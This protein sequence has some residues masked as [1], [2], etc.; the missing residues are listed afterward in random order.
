MENSFQQT[1]NI[2]GLSSGSCVKTVTNILCGIPGISSVN[3]DSAMKKAEVNS[4]HLI[5]TQILKDALINT[6]Y[7]ISEL[8]MF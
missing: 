1:F 6:H 8:P 5:A 3:I 4:H 2:G 7:S